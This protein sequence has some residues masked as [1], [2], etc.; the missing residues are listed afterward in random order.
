MRSRARGLATLF[1]TLLLVG[2]GAALVAALQA[3]SPTVGPPIEVETGRDPQEVPSPTAGRVVPGQASDD[4]EGGNGGD[5]EPGTGGDD[6]AG[7]DDDSGGDGGGGD[8]GDDGGSDNGD[9]DGDGD[10]DN[11]DDDD[12]D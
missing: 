4:D 5:D 3:D 10:D 2:L 9:D 1:I 8:E 6:D 12:E 11:D 7:S